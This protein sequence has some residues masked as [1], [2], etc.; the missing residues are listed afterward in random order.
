ML[1]VD[2]FGS[3]QGLLTIFDILEEIVGDIDSEPQA[4]Q[5]QD[6]SWLLD[7]MLSVDD[8]KVIGD[9]QKRFEDEE[10]SKLFR[11]FHNDLAVLEL[12]SDKA[13]LTCCQLGWHGSL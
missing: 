9:I 4:T 11:R 12:V 13:N 1:V 2:E 10:M 3:T 5:R 7:G 8:F 6:G